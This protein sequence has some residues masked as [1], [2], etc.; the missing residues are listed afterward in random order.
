[1]Y[2]WTLKRIKELTRN[3]I[4][5]I[6]GKS[7]KYE[8]IM[9][10]LKGDMKVWRKKEKQRLNA[11]LVH[12]KEKRQRELDERLNK[13]PPEIDRYA[14]CTVF[15]RNKYENLEVKGNIAEVIGNVILDEEEKSI[16]C[17]NPKFA[18]LQR[19][20]SEQ[21]EKDIEIGFTKIRY[22]LSRRKKIK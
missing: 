22:E 2:Y 9:K 19:L 4:K 13:L 3:W 8:S 17:M 16:L 21:M 10:C 15:N 20:C 6:V 18:V 14:E 5:R 1:M 12:F 11:K 7:R